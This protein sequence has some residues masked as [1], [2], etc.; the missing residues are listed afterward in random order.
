MRQ[1]YCKR[2]GRNAIVI[3]KRT[4]GGSG[5]GNRKKDPFEDD[6][7]TG[8]PTREE[9]WQRF[10]DSEYPNNKRLDDLETRIS[11]LERRVESLGG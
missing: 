7:P 5:M 9:F 4:K 3:R 1:R 11:R 10:M 6:E 2:T 8:M